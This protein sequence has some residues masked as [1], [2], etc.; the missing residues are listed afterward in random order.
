MLHLNFNLAKI[1]TKTIIILL[2]GI[3]LFTNIINAQKA[4]IKGTVTDTINKQTLFHAIIILLNGK[5]SVL[6]KV[7]R[8]N[9]KGDFEL[10]NL[11]AGKYVLLITYP[12][13]ADYTDTFFLNDTTKY[14]TTNISLISKAH[15]LEEVV[16]KQT[17]GSIKLKGDTTEYNADSF[18][19]QANAT[20]EELLKKLPGIQVGKNGQITAQGQ[21]VQKVLVDGEEFFGD[22]PTLIT[23]NIRADMVAKVQVFDKKSDQATFTGI[24]DGG[25]IKTLNIKIKDNKKH[26]YF[27]KLSAGRATDGYNDNQVMLNSFKNKQKIAVFGIASNIGATGLSSQDQQ[28]YGDGSSE[29]IKIGDIDVI[30]SF[31]GND[32]SG[33][34]G[35]YGGTG[36]PIVR[37]GGL[38]YN[39]KWED[40]KQ[41]INANYKIFQLSIGGSS[42]TNSEY[43]L[44]DSL[45]FNTIK[46]N[47]YN[48]VLR[49]KLNGNYDIKLDSTSS[50]NI[51]SE[52]ALEHKN[53]FN[54]YITEARS[55][56]NSLVNNSLRTT[57][58]TGDNNSI[59][60]EILWRKKL[61]KTGRTVSIDFKENYV[62]KSTT[63]YLFSQNKYFSNNLILPSLID[64][65][66]QYKTNNSAILAFDL[67]TTYSEPLSSTSTLVINYELIVDNSNSNRSSFNKSTSGKY[68]LFDSTYSNEY[69]FN[70]IINKSGIFYSSLKKKLQF[71][72]GS[73]IGIT[74]FHQMD[75][76]SLVVANRNFINWYPQANLS[77][78]I[79]SQ[80][81]IFFS[82][83]GST[84]QPNLQQIQP[85]HSN[86]DPLNIVIGNPY[87]KPSFL[88]RLGISYN[89][90]KPLTQRYMYFGLNYIFA[91]NAFSTNNNIDILGRR[92][93]Q[94]IN[95][96]GNYSISGDFN[97]N[98]KWKKPDINLSVSSNFTENRNANITN[99]LQNITNSG[100]YSIGFGLGKQKENI[101]DNNIRFSATY[102]KSTSTIQKNITTQYWTYNIRP[103]C[104]F[105]LPLKTQ[106]H[107]DIDFQ[108]RPKTAAFDN[109]TNVIFWNAWFGKKI[110]KSEALLIKLSANDILNSNIGYNRSVSS[111]FISQNTSSTIKRYF[112]ISAVW[113]FTKNTPKI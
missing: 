54:S 3:F 38:H 65:T 63:G 62:T 49:N 19:V 25:K 93:S 28:N 23:Q 105:F 78:S 72:F 88:N 84:T 91:D 53:A 86:D 22:D 26:G 102:T 16:V 7:A 50:I 30:G 110:L 55:K 40:D 20:V 58:S 90:F 80:K 59:N 57:T 21:K 70:S 2:F 9:E 41:S 112:M 103:D 37:T 43:I 61:T 32:I 79:A 1:F 96:N 17:I 100:F 101:Y 74:N 29:S 36:N 31:N 92:V 11:M 15:L 35:N 107:T 68:D 67:K 60:T 82:Y 5:D 77:Y 71:N 6:Y 33:W 99:Y 95:V 104:D 47:F 18:H 109:N 89:S 56:S 81:Y 111:N 4:L 45:Y 75:K 85:I 98:Y 113:S 106:L 12:N 64:T 44:P 8:T 42:I 87:L 108:F 76:I 83:N 73:N 97:Y 34:N 46:Q 69:T 27:G 10:N 51:K 94:T 13:Y 66:N 14:W 52:G 24:D 39:N 48:Q